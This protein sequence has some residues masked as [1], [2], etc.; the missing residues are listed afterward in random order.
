[1]TRAT[2]MSAAGLLDNRPS[3]ISPVFPGTEIIAAAADNLLA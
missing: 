1:M 3:P 2:I